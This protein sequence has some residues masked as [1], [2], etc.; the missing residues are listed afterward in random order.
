M[1]QILNK[2]TSTE[3]NCPYVCEAYG[4]N[5][6]YRAHMLPQTDAILDRAIN[7]SVGVVD[8]GLGSAFGITIN[9]TDA[10]IGSVAEKIKAYV[11]EIG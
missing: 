3:Y 11:K 5:I 10:Q 9:D 4:R 1:E 7:V 6:E 8:K 2:K